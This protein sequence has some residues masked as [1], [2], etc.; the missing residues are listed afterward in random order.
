MFQVHDINDR[1]ENLYQNLSREAID[2]V[3]KPPDFTKEIAKFEQILDQRQKQLDSVKQGIQ[4][5]LNDLTTENNK[6]REK[7]KI[8]NAENNRIEKYHVLQHGIDEYIQKRTEQLRDQLN[9]AKKSLENKSK[10][11]EQV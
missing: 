7:N 4:N 8:L 10:E 11:L 5:K 9:S 1:L 3:T 2:Q 6:L